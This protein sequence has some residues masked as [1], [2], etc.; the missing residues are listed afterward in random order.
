M[1]FWLF[2]EAFVLT[3]QPKTVKQFKIQLND[4]QKSNPKIN[5]MSKTLDNNQPINYERPH[6]RKINNSIIDAHVMSN[7][8]LSF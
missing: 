5:V 8:I 6:D 2:L 3:N 7:T 1:K 4:K